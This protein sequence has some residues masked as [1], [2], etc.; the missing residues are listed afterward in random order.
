ML[1]TGRQRGLVNEAALTRKLASIV[2]VD[3]AGY[4]A[5]AESDE[6]A[7]VAAIAELKRRIEQCAAVHGGRVFNSAGDGFMLEFPTASA[8]LQA[9]AALSEDPLALRIGV[10]AGEVSVLDNG[11]LLGHGVNIAARL[12][13]MARPRGVVASEDVHRS[14]R[15]PLAARLVHAGSIKL[16]KMQETLS[17]YTLDAGKLRNRL[18]Q[19]LRNSPRTALGAAGLVLIA[20]IAAVGLTLNGSRS[21]RAAVFTFSAPASDAQLT[22]L[23]E[24]V[25]GEIVGTMNEIG[26]ETV[27]R[28]ETR[29]PEGSLERARQLGA[30]FSVGGDVVREGDTVRVS[31]RLDDVRE[32]ATIWSE[33]FEHPAGEADGL[34]LYVSAHAV[35]VMRCAVQARREMPRLERNL[36]VLL[37]RSCAVQPND[38]TG[39]ETLELARRF[40]AA[41]PRSSLAQGRLAF[42]AANASEGMEEPLGE[43]LRQEAIRTAD[44]ALRIDRTNTNAATAKAWASR[45]GMSRL[46]YERLLQGLLRDAP[47]ANSL[48]TSYANILRGVGRN[49]EAVV[50]ARRALTNNPLSPS[51]VYALAW[52]LA[53]TGHSREANEIL[54]RHGERWPGDDGI[55][56]GRFRVSF[57]FGSPAETLVLLEQAPPNQWLDDEARLWRLVINAMASGN[58]SQRR[59]AAEAV[60]SQADFDSNLRVA[61]LGRLGDVD[62]AFEAA[63]IQLREVGPEAWWG[64]FF[65]PSAANLRR[66]PR[67]MP[68][69]RRVGLI[70]YWRTTDHWPDFCAEPDLPFDCRAEA[71]R[72]AAAE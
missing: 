6:L 15:G 17:V 7:A 69:M 67:F 49:E 24:A 3:V 48:N 35:H 72:L 8:A 33:T 41:V 44:L 19:R 14:V 52:S 66:D 47:E 36:M 56:W 71:A 45:P 38:Q 50:Y 42:A 54:E 26:M 25:P 5:R 30:A 61:L 53:L 37:L 16:E 59:R 57:W 64:I 68:L 27:S 58:A 29:D 43:Q 2:A 11:D 51:A 9:G 40:A 18:L 60:K 39:L 4:S 65:E 10:H 31:V 1:G 55:W 20:V 23:A 13:Q 46:D 34:R 22:S 63:E 70:D 12:Q 62:G 21:A 32:R 28:A